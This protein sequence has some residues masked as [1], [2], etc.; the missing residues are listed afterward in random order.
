MYTVSTC[1]DRTLCTVSRA[2]CAYVVVVNSTQVA[3][4][5]WGRSSSS[6]WCLASPRGGLTCARSSSLAGHSSIPP[7]PLD[8]LFILPNK[9]LLFNSPPRTE[10]PFSKRGTVHQLCL[11]DAS[12]YPP[13]L[14]GVSKRSGISASYRLRYFRSVFSPIYLFFF[15]FFSFISP[16]TSPTHIMSAR[17]PP[18]A[19][20][21]GNRFAQF[22]LVLL[23]KIAGEWILV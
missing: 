8:S 20:G 15:F 19:R 16:S 22:K 2:N 1:T 6:L 21:M 12:L 11:L 18:G 13:K 4:R 5:A 3:S 23:G 9:E 17:G 14:P 10:E 7:P